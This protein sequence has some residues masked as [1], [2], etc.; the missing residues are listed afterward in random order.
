MKLRVEISLYHLTEN[1]IPYIDDVI[2]RLKNQEGITL[3]NNELST[4]IYGEYDRVM[5]SINQEMK[6]TFQSNIKLV[7]VAKY[8]CPSE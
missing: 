8:H 1:F 2:G 4:Q 7:F 3:S 5:N 6:L